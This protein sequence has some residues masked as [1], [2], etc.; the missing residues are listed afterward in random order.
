MRVKQI[1]VPTTPK[2]LVQLLDEVIKTAGSI[3]LQ[4]PEANTNIVYFGDLTSQPI[5]LR[6]K[7]NAHIPVSSLKAVYV[8]GTSGDKI[9]IVGF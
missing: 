9:T 2:N 8:K 7:A 6:P 3:G 5:E 1:D 4:A